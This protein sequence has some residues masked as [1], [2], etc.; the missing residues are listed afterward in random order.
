FN[1]CG[2]F[3]AVRSTLPSTPGT[4]ETIRRALV[5][6]G[7]RESS[8]CS[9]LA[10]S[11]HRPP[12]SVTLS[13]NR[14]RRSGYRAGARRERSGA[15]VAGGCAARIRARISSRAGTVPP[16]RAEAL[17]RHRRQVALPRPWI[18]QS[19]SEDSQ[20]LSK[21]SIGPG[22]PQD[23]RR[24]ARDD[25]LVQ[26]LRYFGAPRQQLVVQ[27]D[28][29]RTHVGAGPAERRGKRERGVLSR[30]EMRRE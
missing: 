1:S 19:R 6:S 7:M 22:L 29:H 20:Q 17:A 21:D 2:S 18:R 16:L 24:D 10:T 13:A 23:E 4:S 8:S 15:S 25:A 3:T 14:A 26:R 28:P 30:I 12:T 9:E 5:N 11:T 27:I